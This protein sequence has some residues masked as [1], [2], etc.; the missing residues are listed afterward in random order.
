MSHISKDFKCV[1][2]LAKRRKKAFKSEGLAYSKQLDDS[3]LCS[4]LVEGRTLNIIAGCHL[5]GLLCQG[6]S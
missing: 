5:D 1:S 2:S 6:V 3:G 4:E